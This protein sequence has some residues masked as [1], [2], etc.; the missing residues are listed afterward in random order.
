MVVFLKV[1]VG[2]LLAAHG[3]VHLLYFVPKPDDPTWPFT[4][5][6]SWLVPEPARRPVAVALVAVTVVAFV[7]LGLAVTGFPGLRVIWPGLAVVGSIASLATLAVYWNAQLLAG[8]AID[9][10]VL[11]LAFWRP[12]WTDGLGG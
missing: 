6:R 5:E 11:V 12:E 3:L 9:V 2:I 4:V 7:L 1:V 8:I 10:V